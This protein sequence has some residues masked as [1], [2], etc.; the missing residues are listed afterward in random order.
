MLVKPEE[1]NKILNLSSTLQVNRGKKLYEQDRVRIINASIDDEENYSIETS[2]EDT[3]IYSNFVS[4]TKNKSNIISKCDCKEHT[5][6]GTTCSHI[7]ASLFDIYID[8]E[9]YQKFKNSD[10]EKKKIVYNLV[11]ESFAKKY[12]SIENSSKSIKKV[13][14]NFLEI[15]QNEFVVFYNFLMS[16]YFKY[17]YN[18]WIL[19][20]NS[21][22][23]K[24][25][26]VKIIEVEEKL[27]NIL[28]YVNYE[29]DRLKL[30]LAMADKKF[31]IQNEKLYY[32]EDGIIYLCPKEFTIFMLPIIFFVKNRKEETIIIEKDNIKSFVKNILFNILPFIEI[33]DDTKILDKYKYITP[34]SNLYLDI[35]EENNIVA[36][37]TFEYDEYKFNAYEKNSEN[38][39]IRN[40]IYEL[41]IKRTLEE[42]GFIKNGN[43]VCIL[44]EDKKY[45]FLRDGIKKLDT[46]FEIFVTDKFK[47]KQIISPKNISLGVNLINNL[48]ELDLSNLNISQEDLKGILKTYK[49]KK[50]YFKLKNGDYID[51]EN[52][53]I[54]SLSVLLDEVGIS[55]ISDGKIIVPKY[56]A[57]YL[58]KILSSNDN[59]I[60]K[61]NI[62]F[63]N[64]IDK[65]ENLQMQEWK[66]P[67]GL[68]ATLREYQVLGYNWLKTLQKYEFGGVLADDMGLGKT[69]QVIALLL[70]A[71]QNNNG[72]S[73]VVCPSSLYLNWYKEIERF[74]PS[75]KSLVI[76]GNAKK[77]EELI[78]EIKRYDVIITSYDILKRD[79]EKYNNIKFNYV[80]ADEAQYI[81]NNNTQNAKALKLIKSKN[82][83]ALTG[84]PMENS[85][86]EL[87]SIFD[88]AMS[89]YLFS[90]SKFKEIYEKPIVRENDKK[91]SENLS[92]IISPFILRRIKKEVLKDL[93]DKTETIMYN[94]MGEKQQKV[95]DT[96]L[97]QAKKEIRQE[98]EKS[99]FE[100]SQIKILSLITR[101][102][103]ICLHPKLFIENYNGES[104][105]LIQCIEVIKDAILS[106]H[107]ILVFSGF[108]S[109]FE[110][111]EEEF[112]KENIKFF[113]LTGSTK[114]D[115][116]LELV[117]KFNN[118]NDANVF[119]VSLKAGGTGL[120][121]VG[122]DMVMHFDP[123]WN[124]SVETQATDRTYRIGQKKDVQVFKYITENSIEEKIQEIQ[125]K[126]K[127]LI[128]RVIKNGENFINKL[129]KE[130]IMKLFEN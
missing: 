40:E 93:P 84:T 57:M 127:D 14:K 109:M 30:K 102:R 32:F 122:A 15:W 7:I 85:L 128:D 38:K 119:L 114:S 110:I 92:K 121:L 60:A 112:K 105:K 43:S 126:K 47:K 52:K 59:I 25:E 46:K 88:F 65:I 116:R 9:K 24:E 50:K 29:D 125:E 124:L 20:I 66:L 21:F 64:I 5:L 86:S 68:N 73:I 45:V 95:Y 123:W 4:I 130:E 72:T 58:D 104:S 94:Q 28:A 100:K 76:S 51:L 19:A 118:T 69:I 80:I 90:Y 39:E 117:E 31:F 83:I 99:N 36:D 67:S 13:L 3:S 107:K 53:G 34:K 1:I 2:V 33:K 22:I 23:K 48:I 54:Q 79:I 74:A 42:I 17:S 77:R 11:D 108:T 49:I 27:P 71:K 120:N 12:I 113:K 75:L 91:K 8:F 6:N 111:F 89:G 115:K 56:R 61:K 129:D 78:S 44:N 97:I 103:Q 98:L 63:E 16:L 10:I 62:K 106:G 26:N 70:D 81:K 55:E 82:R 41:G 101:L 35:N 37:V 96:F 18:Q 87:W